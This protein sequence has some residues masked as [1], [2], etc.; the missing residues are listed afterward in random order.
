M[1]KF[2]RF[3]ETIKKK[4][5]NRIVS[6]TVR[7]MVTDCEGAVY[8]TDL[9]IQEGNRLSGYSHNTAE[10]LKKYHTGDEY[11]VTDKRFYNGIVRGSAALIIF[12]L[13]QTSAGIDWTVY[14]NQDMAEGSITLALG[15]GAHK[16]VFKSDARAGDELS[17][18]ASSRRCLKNGAPAEKDGF[19][20]YC[21]ACDSK[22]PVRVEDKKSARLYVEFDEMKDGDGA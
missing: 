13:G 4:R 14:P 11:A 12:N 8:F 7:P 16:A 15:E 5:N 21:A 2:I 22:H 1:P 17:L 18:L 19:F 9:M 10:M 20:Q 6:V 3:T